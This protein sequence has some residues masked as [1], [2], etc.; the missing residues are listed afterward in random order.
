M[1]SQS[2]VEDQRDAKDKKI[3]EQAKRLCEFQEYILLCEKKIKHFFPSHEF[4]STEKNFKQGLN[5]EET[6]NNEI[7]NLNQLI[8]LKEDVLFF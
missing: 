3:I 8:K 2:G 1:K 6:Y 4:P 5:L 7:E